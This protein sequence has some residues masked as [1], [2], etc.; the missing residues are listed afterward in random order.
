MAKKSK[1]QNQTPTCACEY[2]RSERTITRAFADSA[3]ATATRP[4]I[5]TQ[6]QIMKNIWHVA[7]VV[8]MVSRLAE[9]LDIYEF[10]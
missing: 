2:Q 5:T 1:L 9:R 6:V 3:L 10:G 4:K 7:C 8:T